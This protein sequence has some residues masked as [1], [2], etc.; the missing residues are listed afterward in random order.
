MGIYRWSSGQYYEGEFFIDMR[1]GFGKMVW[2]NGDVY[3]G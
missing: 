2:V 3:E 1:D